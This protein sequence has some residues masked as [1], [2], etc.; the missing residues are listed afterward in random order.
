ML[1]L[2]SFIFRVVC[3]LHSATL[4]LSLFHSLSFVDLLSRPPPPLSLI[5]LSLSLP[6]AA[7][8][9]IQGDEFTS[10][11]REPLSP[12][13]LLLAA[14]YT[15][16]YIDSNIQSNYFLNSKKRLFT[17]ASSWS[18]TCKCI[19][20]KTCIIAFLSSHTDGNFHIR[21]CTD[22]VHEAVIKKLHDQFYSDWLF[23]KMFVLIPTC[24]LVNVFACLLT[25]LLHANQAYAT[26]KMQKYTFIGI[27]EFI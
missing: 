23:C 11:S 24:S 6:S 5:C 25:T 17:Q 2:F 7:F 12:D 27:Q 15:E 4:C 14:T 3:L 10:S 20:I 26:M 21:W 1:L 22:T 13:L 18:G 16:I 19:H 8:N 9:A